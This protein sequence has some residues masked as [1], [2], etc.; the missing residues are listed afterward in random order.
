MDIH[1][2]IGIDAEKVA[3]E[4]KKEGI[5]A[6]EDIGG[7]VFDMVFDDIYDALGDWIKD[8]HI[9]EELY[10]TPGGPLYVLRDEDVVGRMQTLAILPD[11]EFKCS[12]PDVRA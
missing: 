10:E 7:S 2:V 4:L 3:Q 8:R 9:V 12:G 6:L 11:A 5:I 1:S